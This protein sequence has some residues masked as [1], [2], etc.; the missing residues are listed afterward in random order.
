MKLGNRDRVLG[1]QKS[2]SEVT[3]KCAARVS[4]WMQTVRRRGRSATRQ[5]AE[6][7]KTL[8]LLLALCAISVDSAAAQSRRL[9]PKIG[10]VWNGTES[11]AAPYRQPY[12]E[13]MR[14]L[15][16]IDGQTAQFLVRYDDGDSSRFPA[17]MVE[18]LTLDVDILVVV[19]KALAAARRATTTVPIVCLDLYDPIAE[20]ITSSLAKPGGNITGVSWQSIETAGKRLELAKELIP[21]LRRVALLTD[22]GDAGA[23]IEANGLRRT[24]TSVGLK[25]RTFAL[26]YASELPAAFA[27]IKSDPPEL[28]VISTNPLM[29]LHID[30]IARFASSISVPTVSEVAEFAEAGILLTYGAD[31]SETFKHGA[32]QVDR[33]LNGM[34]PGDL[35][36]E[37]PTKFELVVNMRTARSLGLTVPEA[38]MVRATKV[39]P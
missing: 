3:V 18:L 27:A 23:A 13:Q 9:P 10:E 14:A 32:V 6:R 24:A 11:Q 8:L 33:I 38:I 21:G 20:G 1:A 5:R 22:A 4:V 39:I 31:V 28:L 34:K 26:R 35:P 37:Q 36:F 15:G 7:W 29:A 19:D 16:W 30:E 25:L 12:I 17:L 2:G